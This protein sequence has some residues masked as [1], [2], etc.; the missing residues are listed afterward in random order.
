MKQATLMPRDIEVL[1]TA[2]H[3]VVKVGRHREECTN[4]EKAQEIGK[5]MSRAMNRNA[6]LYAVGYSSGVPTAAL[7]G[8]YKDM[9]IMFEPEP[10]NKKDRENKVYLSNHPDYTP[11][12][13][14]DTSGRDL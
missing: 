12:P 9:W 5:T 6:L 2:T 3:F 8:T 4:I 10:E 7:I 14:P 13:L 1:E 11:T